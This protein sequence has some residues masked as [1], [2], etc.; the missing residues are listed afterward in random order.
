MGHWITVFRNFCFAYFHVLCRP[1][2][3]GKSGLKVN[4][5]N[6]WNS[7]DNETVMASSLNCFKTRLDRLYALRRWASLCISS[8]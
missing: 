3:A 5:C 1:T 7:L 2:Y 8:T 6:R 4:I